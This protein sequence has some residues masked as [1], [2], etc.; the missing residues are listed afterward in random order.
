VSNL[1]LLAVYSIN[2]VWIHPSSVNIS[3]ICI[4]IIND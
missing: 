1:F 4:F 2:F 3:W